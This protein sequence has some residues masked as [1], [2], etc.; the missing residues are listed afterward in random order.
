MAA[1]IGLMQSLQSSCSTDRLGIDL[2]A[3]YLLASL[4]C[5]CHFG[6]GHSNF[7]CKM[8]LVDGS[9]LIINGSDCSNLHLEECWHRCSD[10]LQQSHRSHLLLF[11]LHHLLQRLKQLHSLPLLA[12]VQVSSVVVFA[13]TP[14]TFS[15]SSDT[16]APSCTIVS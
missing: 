7:S 15:L 14:C 16:T 9:P 4:Y 8:S 5:C 13:A 11:H 6:T 12:S 3:G 10:L 1:G 2:I